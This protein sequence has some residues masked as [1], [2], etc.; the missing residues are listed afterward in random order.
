MKVPID[1][2]PRDMFEGEA[3]QRF[4]EGLKLA[5]SCSKEMQALQPKRGWGKVTEALN[6]LI[7]NGYKLSRTRALTRQALLQDTDRIA[8]TQINTEKS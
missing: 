3:T 2:Q 6:H 1:C 4:I 7:S 8:A 5:A